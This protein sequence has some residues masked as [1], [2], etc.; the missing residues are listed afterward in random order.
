MVEAEDSFTTAL[1]L[2][3]LPRLS[4]ACTIM[5]AVFPAMFVCVAGIITSAD[6]GVSLTVMAAVP[7]VSVNT[8]ADSVEFPSTESLTRIL[9]TCVPGRNTVVAQVFPLSW[10]NCIVPDVDVIVMFCAYDTLLP[11]TSCMLTCIDPGELD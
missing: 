7:V 3:L 2:A 9:F 4:F 5:V 6:A 1:E 10:L 8:A 11:F